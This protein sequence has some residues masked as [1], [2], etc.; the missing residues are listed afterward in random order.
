MFWVDL[1]SDNTK[2]RWFFLGLATLSQISATIIRMGVPALMP[3]IKRDLSLSH[4]EVGFISSVLT[5]APQAL[6]FPE[7]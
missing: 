6:G 4:T 2:K 5:E 1:I 3:F 7:D